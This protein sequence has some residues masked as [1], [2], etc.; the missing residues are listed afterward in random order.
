[1]QLEQSPFL[2]VIS[3]QRIQQTL[4]FMGQPADA[5]LTPAICPGDLPKDPE[6]RFPRRLHCEPGESIRSGLKAVNCRT[7]DSL[8]QEQATADGKE[9]VLKALGEAVAEH[10]AEV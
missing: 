2:S 8:A 3:E 10:S 9:R 5:R 7:G 6:R 1:V 4:R